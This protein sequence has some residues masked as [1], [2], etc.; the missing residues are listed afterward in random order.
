MTRLSAS[1][2]A[3]R[4]ACAKC[5]TGLHIRAKGRWI[6]SGTFFHNTKRERD[7]RRRRAESQGELAPR[8]P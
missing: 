3:A 7:E 6:M 1:H 8:N 5:G 4:A 2:P